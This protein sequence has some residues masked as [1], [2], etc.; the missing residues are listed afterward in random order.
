[1]NRSPAAKRGCLSQDAPAIEANLQH[2]WTVVG[3]SAPDYDGR[4]AALDERVE[5]DLPTPAE[6]SQ[7]RR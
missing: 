2:G 1:V 5:L 4:T 7:D 3:G 6:I